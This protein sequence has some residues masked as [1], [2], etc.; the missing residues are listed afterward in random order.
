[1]FFGGDRPKSAA[2]PRIVRRI[3]RRRPGFVDHDPVALR[4]RRWPRS[5]AGFAG[6]HRHPAV[7]TQAFNF[8]PF[9]VFQTPFKR[10]NMFAAGH[11]DVSDGITVYGRGLFSNN[12]V[13]TIIAPSGVFASSVAVPLSNPFLTAAQR[14]YFCANADF[15]PAVAGNQTLTAAQCAAGATALTPDRCRLSSE[16]TVGLR[17]RTPEV[18]PRVSS[19]NTQ[20][21]DFKAGVRGDI[22]DSIGFDAFVSRGE[23]TNTQSI[24]NY[25]L[26][27][28]VRQAL[29]ATN[30][31]DLP[32]RDQRLRSAQHLRSRRLDHAG[33]GRLHQRRQHLDRR[34][35]ACRRR[36]ASSTATSASRRRSPTSRSASRS[37]PNIASIRRRR[38]PTSS[39]RRRANSAAPVAQPR[40]SAAASRSTK[41]LPKSSRRWSPIVRSSTA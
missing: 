13:D 36:A 18:G 10:Y 4:H 12:T 32:D 28:R 2:D 30:T 34:A 25:V 23:S 29:L 20:M 41:A 22:T 37:V 19:Y 31:D 39:P 7:T 27:S 6:R 14:T 9:N 3:L 5:A 17:R 33:A 11:Y 35:P 40:T 21:F 15:N 16:F 8:N 38:S 24:Q 1:M 26:L